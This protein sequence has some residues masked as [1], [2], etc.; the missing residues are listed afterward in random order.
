MVKYCPRCKNNLEAEGHFVPNTA[1][2]DGWSGY[3]R[4]CMYSYNRLRE[5]KARKDALDTLGAKC[6]KCGIMDQRVLAIDHINSNGAAER[7]SGLKQ[8]KLYLHVIRNPNVYQILCHNCNWIKWLEQDQGMNAV[9]PE[10]ADL[11]DQRTCSQ[12][13]TLFTPIMMH[14]TK[15]C[16]GRCKTRAYRARKLAQSDT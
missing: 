11:P 6:M 8:T 7:R 2:S 5:A 3:C 14:N 16:S 9:D 12:C 10:V 1:R 15:Y 4:A 13:P